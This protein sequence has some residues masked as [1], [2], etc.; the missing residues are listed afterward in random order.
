MITGVAAPS[1]DVIFTRQASDEPFD[2][3]TNSCAGVTWYQSVPLFVISYVT[4]APAPTVAVG[5]SVARSTKA[6]VVNGFDTA[7]PF[8][9]EYPG[10]NCAVNDFILPTSDCPVAEFATTMSS[11]PSRLMSSEANPA[12]ASLVKAGPATKT[13][14]KGMSAEPLFRY[15]TGAV[16][17][18]RLA[19]RSFKPS[20]LTSINFMRE[21]SS[22]EIRA[23][24]A[25][26][27]FPVSGPLMNAVV[28]RPVATMASTKPSPF[29]SST[30]RPV[31]GWFVSDE[32]VGSLSSAIFSLTRPGLLHVP[33]LMYFLTFN[34]PAS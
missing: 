28:P 20:P 22:T 33:R 26:V 27:R 12:A 19:T 14:L 25:I 7:T 11:R 3:K 9:F 16:L 34:E 1:L 29:T 18:G 32:I 23:D 8:V 6:S 21:K 17:N 15:T 2:G 13:S 24:W 10:M 4:D 31:D 5:V 30:R